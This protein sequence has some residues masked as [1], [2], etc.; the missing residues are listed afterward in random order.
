[1]R[2]CDCE[3]AEEAVQCLNEQGISFNNDSL[4]VK[5]GI[6]LL[7]LG[8]VDIKISMNRFK[9]FAIWYLEDQQLIKE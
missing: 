6:V 2:P 8:S 5:P 7:T 1:M 3:S 9:Q 4:S